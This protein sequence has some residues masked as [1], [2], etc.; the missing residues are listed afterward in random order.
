MGPP[1]NWHGCPPAATTV[2]ARFAK[3][4]R[5]GRQAYDEDLLGL[6]LDLLSGW[7]GETTDSSVKG[8]TSSTIRSSAASHDSVIVPARNSSS[9]GCSRGSPSSRSNGATAGT[10]LVPSPLLITS[11]RSSSIRVA[12]TATCCFS[13]ATLVTRLPERA[14]RKKVRCPGWPTVPATKRSG[15]S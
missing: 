2:W 9:M 13:S 4:A 12:R 3:R 1:Q 6:A 5:A 11:S 7:S 8:K 15:G 14:W 10:V